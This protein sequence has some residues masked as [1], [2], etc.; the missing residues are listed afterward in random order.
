MSLQALGIEYK[1]LTQTRAATM[2]VT[3]KSRQE[4]PA[5][6]NELAGHI[7]QTHIAGPPFC[8]IQFITS[9]Q[10]GFDAEIGFPVSAAME[11]IETA[12]TIGIKTRVFPPLEVLSLT[13]NRPLDTLRASYGTLYAATA[14][15][16]LISDEFAREVYHDWNKVELQFVL[17]NWPKLFAAHLERVLG[18]GASGRLTQGLAQPDVTSTLDARFRWTQAMLERLERAASQDQQYDV[19]SSCAHVF[20]Q[21]QIDKLQAVYAAARARTD[22]PL[23]AID[24]V[25]AFMDQDPG[26]GA[27]PYREGRIIYSSKAPRDAQAYENAQSEAEKKRA[28]CFCP[29]VR[30][31]LA[32]GMSPTFCYCGAGWYRQQWEGAIGRPVTVEIV[33]S[34]L[35]GDELCQFAIHLPQDL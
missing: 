15:R 32:Q 12:D 20:P 17:H 27:K 26:W 2:R 10:D 4:L 6:L 29:I 11:A 18:P 35:R 23:D 13:H 16:G 1:Q 3:L 30:E 24:A 7:P 31:R 22:D 25:I 14:E 5:R 8:I 21:R 19:V 28:Y 9:V 33:K 34:V